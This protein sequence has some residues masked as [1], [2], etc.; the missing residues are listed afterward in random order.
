MRL[1]VLILLANSVLSNAQ[2][3]PDDPYAPLRLYD[4]VWQV[5]P[6]ERPPAEPPDRLEDVCRQLGSYFACQQ[7]VNGKLGALLVFIPAGRSGHYHTQAV[8]P[9]GWAAGRGELEIEGDWWVYSSKAGSGNETVYYRTTNVFMGRDRIHY[10]LARS[11]D[12]KG[13]TVTGSGDEV[14]VAPNAVPN[15]LR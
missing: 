8:M 14:R 12:G 4:G 13:W 2:A 9:E 11:P 3:P 1:A 5:R 7:M 15:K 10:E 6:Q